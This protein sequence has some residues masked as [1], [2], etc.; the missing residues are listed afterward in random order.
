MLA[1]VYI[2]CPFGGTR[3]INPASHEFGVEGLG[4]RV[5]WRCDTG[6]RGK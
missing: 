4:F 3:N 2:G 1:S 6:R 5:F